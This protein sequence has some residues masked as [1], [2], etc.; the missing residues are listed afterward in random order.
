M[1][2]ATT[3]PLDASDETCQKLLVKLSTYLY[4]ATHQNFSVVYPAASAG[5]VRIFVSDS[6]AVSD[7]ARQIVESM[8]KEA[9]AL[10]IEI[11]I[12]SPVA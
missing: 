1:V 8:S 9:S 7:R 12:G 11:R 10:G 3:G 6:H 2:V 5:R 4:A